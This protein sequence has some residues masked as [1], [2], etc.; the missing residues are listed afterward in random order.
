MATNTNHPSS[1]GTVCVDIIFSCKEVNVDDLQDEHIHPDTETITILSDVL[2]KNLPFNT[3]ED[4]AFATSL[5]IRGASIPKITGHAL[6][7]TY[8]FLL[9]RNQQQGLDDVSLSGLI[10]TE[11]QHLY[12]HVPCKMMQTGSIECFSFQSSMGS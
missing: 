7:K 6:G 1:F 5:P 3:Y 9:T 2:I 10:D 8:D 12:L 4:L 11:H